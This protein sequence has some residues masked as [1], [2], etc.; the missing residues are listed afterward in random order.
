MLS[1]NM[2]HPHLKEA[3][4]QGPWKPSQ[5]WSSS[6]GEKERRNDGRGAGNHTTQDN[7]KEGQPGL[8]SL[9]KSSD[10]VI[11]DRICQR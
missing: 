4:A 3:K 9:N 10:V 7:N 1:D 2:E 11:G 8:E 6:K 5:L